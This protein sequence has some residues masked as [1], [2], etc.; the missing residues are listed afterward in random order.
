MGLPKAF[1][2]HKKGNLEEAVL[3]YKRALDQGVKEPNLFQ[4]LGAL[5][6]Q[7][8]ETDA[9]LEIYNQG[10]LLYPTHAGLRGNRGNVLATSHPA[11]AI[12]D[13]LISL[14]LRIA[15]GESVLKSDQF[16]SLITILRDFGLQSWPLAVA[17]Y[18]LR[19][20]GS[21]PMLLGQILVLVDEIDQLSWSKQISTSDLNEFQ[22]AIENSIRACSKL[23]QGELSLSLASHDMS[24]GDITRALERFDHGLTILSQDVP[25]DNDESR[26]R[27]KLIDINSWNFGCGLIKS[28]FLERGWKLYEYGLRTPAEGKQR[29]QRALQK[30]FAS[31]ELSIWR[32]ESL[33]GK[34][35]LLLEEQA[36]GDVMMFLTLVPTLVSEALSVSILVSERLRKIYQRSFGSQLNVITHKDIKKGTISYEMFDYQCPLGSICQHRFTSVD[37]YSPV[38]P[39]LTPNVSR[40]DQLRSE[41]F[42]V[43]PKTASRLIGISWKGGGKP[44]RIR[45]KSIDPSSFS[46]ILTNIDG[47]RFVS[48]QYGKVDTQV[49]AWRAQGLD[50]IHDPRVDPLRDMNLWLDQVAA[51]D[52]VISVANTTIHGSG[53]LNIPTLC[54]LTLQSDWRWFNSEEVTRSYWYPSVGIVRESKLLGWDKAFDDARSWLNMGCPMP[55]GP[56][57]C[58]PIS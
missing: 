3:Q 49:S 4:N 24:K 29:W 38:T 31:S 21:E 47:V 46:K 36:I 54:L 5:Y 57:S 11:S 23:E 41:Y 52:A 14:R 48:L 2:E 17:Q 50:V 55:D 51:C 39:L 34:R 32:G 25:S 45:Q 37:Q 9:A 30:P 8:G 26:K 19:L 15:S 33:I 58:K 13:I 42:R 12:Q 7:R 56:I 28:E 20:V 53:G 18:A 44:G 40:R 10:V 16:R 35:I 43:G 6:R 1:Q 27:Q 22:Y